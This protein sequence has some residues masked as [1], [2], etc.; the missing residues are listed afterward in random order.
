MRSCGAEG[1]QG[2]D[3]AQ[4]GLR[5]DDGVQ[6]DVSH[7]QRTVSTRRADEQP[8]TAGERHHQVRVGEPR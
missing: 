5:V 3:D 7:G 1:R 6:L 4:P 8:A 2:G